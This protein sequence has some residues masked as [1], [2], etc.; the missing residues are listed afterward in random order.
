[1]AKSQ[2]VISKKPRTGAKSFMPRDT[3]IM[4]SVEIVTT[5]NSARKTTMGKKEN[6]ENRSE[7]Q[8]AIR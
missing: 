5:L 2:I 4:R 8:A 7:S 6:A 1:M 3:K